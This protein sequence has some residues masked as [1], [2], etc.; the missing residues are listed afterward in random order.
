MFPVTIITI[1]CSLHSLHNQL[2]MKALLICFICFLVASCT[3]Y[4]LIRSLLP[5]LGMFIVSDMGVAIP[6]G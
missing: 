5:T 1:G 6:T 3:V 2:G 4:F